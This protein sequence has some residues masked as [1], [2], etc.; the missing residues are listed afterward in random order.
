MT[1][2]TYEFQKICLWEPACV[3]GFKFRIQCVDVGGAEVHMT[4]TTQNDGQSTLGG[5]RV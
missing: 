3:S 5:T 1:N 2:V 4:L